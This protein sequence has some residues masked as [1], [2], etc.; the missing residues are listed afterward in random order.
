MAYQ[1]LPEGIIKKIP[2]LYSQ[3]DVKDPTVVTKFFTPWS[4]W[5]WYVIEYDGEDRF[6]G[7]V[8]GFEKEFGYFTRT[9]L[10]SATGPMGLKIERDINWSPKPISEVKKELGMG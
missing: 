8:D 9:E 6:Y 4:N 2:K 1:F 5:T 10:E 7:L 3:E